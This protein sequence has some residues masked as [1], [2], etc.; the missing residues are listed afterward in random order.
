M[1]VFPPLLVEVFLMASFQTSK[2]ET[3]AGTVVRIRISDAALGV[4]GNTPPAGAVD[5]GNIYAYAQNPGSKRKKQLN[6]RGARLQRFTGTGAARKRFTT[7]VPILT[8]TAWEAV[9]VGSTVTL[10]SVEYTV[11]DLVPEA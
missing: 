7:F 3:N 6:A 8:P 1:S 4:L 5:D 2:Y 9:V 11:A 10:N